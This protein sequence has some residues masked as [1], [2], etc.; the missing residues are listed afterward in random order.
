MIK[1]F[2]LAVLAVAG[3]CVLVSACSKDDDKLIDSN[4]LPVE[5]KAFVSTYYPG[6]SVLSTYKDGG[7]YDV[8]LS[9]RHK[10][11]FNRVGDWLEVEAPVGQTIP[12]GFYPSAIDVY[13]T[14]NPVLG[15]GINE[16]TKLRD[17]YEIKTVTGAEL[18]FDSEGSF[19]RYDS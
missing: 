7:N 11:E 1:K 9:N 6:V 12:A 10:I 3:F 13:V 5:A 18:I 19:L 17:G 15:N 8:T 14:D 2:L 4:D 16:I